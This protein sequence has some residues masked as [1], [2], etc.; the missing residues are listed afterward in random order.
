LPT[1]ADAALRPPAAKTSITPGGNVR[2]LNA[3]QRYHLRISV[4][5]SLKPGGFVEL[6][7][8]QAWRHLLIFNC[9]C[10]LAST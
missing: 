9:W 2:N 5:R 1:S 7:T 3:N 4:K 10:F 8:A 6:F